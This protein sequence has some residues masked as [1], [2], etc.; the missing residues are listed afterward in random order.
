MECGSPVASPDRTT[1]EKVESYYT[2]QLSKKGGLDSARTMRGSN[3]VLP[4]GEEVGLSCIPVSGERV[5]LTMNVEKLKDLAIVR[6]TGRIVRGENI[7]TLKGSVIAANDTRLIV[8]DLTEV[9]SIDA[10]GLSALVFLHHWSRSRGIQLKLVN[11]S[12]FVLEVLNRTRLSLVFDISS[13]H[14]GL[15]A[16]VGS[17]GSELPG[18]LA[19]TASTAMSVIA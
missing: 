7:S 10:A 4:G 2:K 9:E 15:V 18:G 12:R 1:E 14:D 6:C 16:F 5:M 11:P 13:F 17:S 19:A 8:M 3:R